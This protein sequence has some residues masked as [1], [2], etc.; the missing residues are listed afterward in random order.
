MTKSLQALANFKGIQDFK[1]DL[2]L[3]QT[4]DGREYMKDMNQKLGVRHLNL[5]QKLADIESDE[6][7]KKMLLK[8]FQGIVRVYILNGFNFAARDIGSPSDPYLRVSIGDKEFNDR[9]N[10]QLDQPCPEF[11][12]KWDFE[13]NFPGCPP[14]V[15]DA[16]D[17]D[18]LFGDDLIGTT[19]VDLED[20][21]FMVEWNAIVNKPIET[22][23]L[24]HSC[25]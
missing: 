17:Y 16:M 21:Y 7:L 18:D 5:T 12:K 9:D 8:K 10:Y 15:I 1:V 22:R 23:Q 11:H 3:L 25:S 2:D 6:I 14:L 13:C 19:V 4:A 20:R 24:Y